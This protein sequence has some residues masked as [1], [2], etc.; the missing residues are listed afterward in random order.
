MKCIILHNK[1]IYLTKTVGNQYGLNVKL[2]TPDLQTFTICK[3]Q[4]GEVAHGL[5]LNVL[6]ADVVAFIPKMVPMLTAEAFYA[7]AMFVL[8]QRVVGATMNLKG[9][10]E[11]T[12][13]TCIGTMEQVI[14]GRW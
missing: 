7:V 1:Q 12:A 13:H 14:M 9:R 5:P 6:P 3:L 4:S 11:K 2:E 10:D 8:K